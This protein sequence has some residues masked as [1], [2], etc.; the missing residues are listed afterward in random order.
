[1]DSHQTM[2]LEDGSEIILIHYLTI[3]DGSEPVQKIACSPN[4][5]TF[6][7]TRARPFPLHRTQEVGVVN[8]PL[9]HKTEEYKRAVEQVAASQRIR[10]V[11]G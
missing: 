6:G 4:V 2:I 7:V 8:C 5:E 9:C 11:T 1:M 3:M 10:K